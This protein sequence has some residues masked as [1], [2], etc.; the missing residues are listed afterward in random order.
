MTV[1]HAIEWFVYVA[2]TGWPVVIGIL[3]RDWWRR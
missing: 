1:R 2:I 3:A